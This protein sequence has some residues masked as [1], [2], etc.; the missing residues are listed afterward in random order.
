MVVRGELPKC[1]GGLFFV[2]N[3]PR[4]VREGTPLVGRGHVTCVDLGKGVV[5][6]VR[7]PPTHHAVTL[8][9]V[10]GRSPSVF[11]S[12]MMPGPPWHSGACNTAVVASPDGSKWYAV[13]EASRAYELRVGVGGL[14]EGLRSKG[15][16]TGHREPVHRAPGL[17]YTYSPLR[18]TPLRIDGRTVRDWTPRER[19]VLLHSCARATASL[20][21]FPLMST[22]YGR[23][24]DWLAGR[25]PLPMGASDAGAGWLVHDARSHRTVEIPCPTGD[26]SSRADVFHVV[27]ARARGGGERSGELIHVLAC[28]VHGFDAY[29]HD[30]SAPLRFTLEK[31]VL[32]LDAREVREVITYEGASGDFPNRVDARTILVNRMNSPPGDDGGGADAGKRGARRRGGARLALFDVVDERVVREIELPHR[33]VG[34]VLARGGRFLLYA[35]L[36]CVV[37]YDLRHDRVVAEVDIPRRAGNF[38]AS[39]L[40][41]PSS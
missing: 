21:V 38:H 6:E 24:G 25:A 11:L 9:D 28:H 7:I 30:A 22:R 8:E 10:V 32:D 18:P 2:Q 26:A 40:R 15:R 1:L 19:P 27:R 16:F 14:Q 33:G 29:V 34:D 17:T 4:S 23:F 36:D 35:T 20:V 31:H 5:T 37:V 3:G 39:L 41:A 12:A 13:E